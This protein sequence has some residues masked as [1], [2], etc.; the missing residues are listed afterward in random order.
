MHPYIEILHTKY[1][2]LHHIRYIST[3]RYIHPASINEL[4]HDSCYLTLVIVGCNYTLEPVPPDAHSPSS[5]PSRRAPEDADL[6][7][8]RTSTVDVMAF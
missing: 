6:L 3:I 5:S 7:P 4:A 2:C 1:E 8:R